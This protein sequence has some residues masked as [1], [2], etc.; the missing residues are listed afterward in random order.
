MCGADDNS[1]EAAKCCASCGIAEVDDIKLVPCDDCDLVNYCSDECQRDHRSEHEANCEERVAELRDE[2]L[3]KQPE[4]THFGDCPICC[5][6]FPLDPL[7]SRMQACCSKMICIG[8]SYSSIVRHWEEKRLRTCPFC[9]H[10][11]P[12]TLEESDKI[13]TKRVEANDPTAIR[14]LGRKHLDEGDYD[15]AFKY[16]TKAADFGDA[17]AHYELSVMYRDEEGVEKDE[18]R[19]IYHLEEASIAGLPLARY[20]LA[21]HEA[22]NGRIERAVKHLIIAA[23][24]GEDNSIN[25]LKEYYKSGFVSKDDFAAALR[26]HHAAVDATKSPQREAAAKYFATHG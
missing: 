3:F 26:A 16:L 21:F 15:S 23:S 13:R 4:G 6:P 25:G 8:C 18:K 9:R 7:K 10:I 17:M 5:V 14:Q 24:L 22:K 20:S 2:I 12:D 19:E 11:V 1:E